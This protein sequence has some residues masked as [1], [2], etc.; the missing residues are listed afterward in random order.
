M[1]LAQSVQVAAPSAAAIVP[2]AHGV[3]TVLPVEH[4]W[5]ALH[6][7]QLSACHRSVPL[8]YEPDG[9]GS[10]ADAPSAQNE[11]AT[12]AAHAVMPLELW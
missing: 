10:G 4:E 1:P 3:G 8:E 9:H 7:V 5:P 6:A 11:P 2:A 12:H